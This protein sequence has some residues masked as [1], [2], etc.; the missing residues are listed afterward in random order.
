MSSE[1]NDTSSNIVVETPTTSSK[2]PEI[3]SSFNIS[4]QDDFELVLNS[5]DFTQ[6]ILN[7]ICPTLIITD[8]FSLTN[9]IIITEPINISFTTKSFNTQKNNRIY[10][11]TP[12]SSTIHINCDIEDILDTTLSIDGLSLEVNW[13]NSC[14]PTIETAFKHINVSSYNSIIASAYD[15]ILPGGSSTS[16]ISSV[17]Y[18]KTAKKDTLYEGATIVIRDNIIK[19]QIP[20]EVNDSAIS[21]SYLDF[22]VDNGTYEIIGATTDYLSLTFGEN[23]IFVK[24]T[25]ND[26]NCHYYK[27]Y[28]ERKNSGIPIVNITTDAPVTNKIDYISGTMIIDNI[29]YSLRIKG[30]GNSS[31]SSF[32]KKSYRLKLDKK[33]EILGMEDDKDWVLVS[34]YADKSLIR[35]CIATDMANVLSGLEYTPAHTLI[36]LFYNGEYMGIYTIAEKIEEGKKKV[37]INGDVDDNNNNVSD[38][39]STEPLDIG[40]LIEYGWN[41]DEENVYGVDYFDTEHTIRLFVKEPEITVPYTKEMRYIMDYMNKVDAAITSGGNYEDYIDMDSWVD[42]FILVE[43]SNNTEVSFYRSCY[44]YKKAGGKLYLGPI[45]DYDMAFGNFLG[46]VQTYDVWSSGE[47]TYK[48][49]CE[50]TFMKYLVKDPKFMSMVKA[51]WNEIKNTLLQAGLDAADKYSALL[52]EAQVANFKRWNIMKSQIGMGASNYWKYNTYEL[53]ILYIKEFLQKRYD[54]IDQE[55]NT[56][57]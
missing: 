38:T 18:Y 9:D 46:D 43:L 21:K 28:V 45:W 4:N 51:R 2:K 42:W 56:K 49:T 27:L 47:A 29:E 30:R 25:D 11:K 52:S 23:D 14:A 5:T 36:D 1:L 24:T 7:N 39:S 35:N 12:K 20:H 50:Y 26:G 40:F 10:I 41:F 3:T 8:D 53:Q 48:Y 16:I 6:C 37:N 17:S 44:L 33:S 13:E 34:S 22:I 31:W 55:L 19:L 54:W 32:P 15:K 57:W